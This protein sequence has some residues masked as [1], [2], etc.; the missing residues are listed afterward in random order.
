MITRDPSW[1]DTDIL[2]QGHWSLDSFPFFADD[3]NSQITLTITTYR[4]SRET[5]RHPRQV[6]PPR[7]NKTSIVSHV[8]RGEEHYIFNSMVKVVEKA[9]KTIER[10][11]ASFLALLSM[12]QLLQAALM[13]DVKI[14][15]FTNSSLSLDGPLIRESIMKSKPFLDESD[16]EIFIEKG[17]T[18]HKKNQGGRWF[19]CVCEKFQYASTFPPLRYPGVSQHHRC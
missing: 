6:W 5:I 12:E 8:A 10:E 1:R 7:K 9:T 14:W 18:L 2:A 11:N 13:G 19:V 16:T 3:R 17:D 4:L 15:R